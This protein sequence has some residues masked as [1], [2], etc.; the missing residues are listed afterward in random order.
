MAPRLIVIAALGTILTGC[1]S[2]GKYNALKL[3]KDQAVEALGN[4]E[5]AKARAEGL[6]QSYK[7]Q[8]ELLGKQ[9]GDLGTLVSNLQ[10]ENQRLRDQY[11]QAMAAVNDLKQQL[12][13]TGGG[14]IDERVAKPIEELAGKYPEYM[15]FDRERGVIKLKSDVTFDKGSAELTPQARTVIG[16]IAQILNSGP[17]ASY[18]M[19]V[20]GHTDNTRVVHKETIAAG[21]KDNWYLSAHRAITVGEELIRHQ[22]SPRRFGV[23]G[24]A[25][26][27]PIAPNTTTAGQARNRRVEL[28]LLPT[29]YRAGT[30]VADAPTTPVRATP[31]KAQPL[32]K[33]VSAE[34]R[35]IL[36]K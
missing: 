21:H 6:A 7:D 30:S 32:G 22:V 2:Q 20:A 24:Y 9:G 1:V 13:K 4:A 8:L 14:P 23:L 11:D 33:E 26:Q 34:P 12:G 29:T 16:K 3:E 35:P 25:D 18:E 5:T 36:I 19:L 27:R 31:R 17:A 15:E 28:V 10:T